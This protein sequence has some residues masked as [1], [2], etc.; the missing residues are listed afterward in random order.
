MESLLRREKTNEE[1]IMDYENRHSLEP[2]KKVLDEM[3]KSLRNKNEILSDT[4]NYY[5]GILVAFMI[6]GGDE[7]PFIEYIVSLLNANI[8]SNNGA[9]SDDTKNML[10]LLENSKTEYYLEVLSRVKRA[11]NNDSQF[12]SLRDFKEYYRML[13]NAIKAKANSKILLEFANTLLTASVVSDNVLQSVP[14]EYKAQL[15]KIIDDIQMQQ[16]SISFNKR[17]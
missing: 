11:V 7:T 14:Y 13:M 6:S 10:E 9:L 1:R 5:C 15:Q 16:A 2:C 17:N 3:V 12:L 4:F 8:I